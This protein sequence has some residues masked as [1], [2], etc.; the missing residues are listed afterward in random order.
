MT[1]QAVD[2]SFDLHGDGVMK[3]P[4]QEYLGDDGIAEDVIPFCE[5]SIVRQELAIGSPSVLDQWR[6]PF[7][8]A[9]V[10]Q[11]EGLFWHK[12]ISRIHLTNPA[13]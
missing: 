1:A 8:I 4:I 7:F 13:S 10:D 6:T 5:A 12:C 3:Q 11:L 9:L 2:G